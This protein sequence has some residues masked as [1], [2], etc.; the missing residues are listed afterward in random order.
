MNFKIIRKANWIA[1]FHVQEIISRSKLQELVTNREAW[2]AAI[3]GVQR[4]RHDW[5][6]ELNWLMAFVLPS[7]S[8]WNE[9]NLSVSS[10]AVTEYFFFSPTE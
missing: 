3:H 7:T 9:M 10:S 6:T 2:C 1:I 8:G 4:V 5:V